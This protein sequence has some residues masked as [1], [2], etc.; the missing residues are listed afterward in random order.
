[1]QKCKG[2][3]IVKFSFLAFLAEFFLNFALKTYGTLEMSPLSAQNNFYIILISYVEGT[4]TIK[5]EFH[6][7]NWKSGWFFWE[8]YCGASFEIIFRQK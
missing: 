4:K 2:Q 3:N 7:F 5:S 8:I 6:V 1:M